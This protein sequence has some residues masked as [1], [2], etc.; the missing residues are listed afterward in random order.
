MHPA[1]ASVLAAYLLI[2]PGAVWLMLYGVAIAFILYLYKRYMV[3]KAFLHWFS[4]GCRRT[5]EVMKKAAF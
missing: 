2:V 4:T 3:G 1:H 5:Q